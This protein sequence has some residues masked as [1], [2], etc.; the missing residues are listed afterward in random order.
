MATTP[1]RRNAISRQKPTLPKDRTSG[2]LTSEPTRA[3]AAG[4]VRDPVTLRSY[5]WGMSRVSP[6]DERV[7]VR[8]SRKRI[9]SSTCP[10]PPKT[11]SNG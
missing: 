6:E 3:R 4:I 7:A 1:F 11:R 2:F 8:A 10:Q 9:K 5:P